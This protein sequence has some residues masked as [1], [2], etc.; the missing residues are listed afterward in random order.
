MSQNTLN[1]RKFIKNSALTAA[2]FYIVPRHVL[3]KGYVPPSDKLNIGA[4]GAF[5]KGWVNLSNSWNNGAENI[6]AMSD[7]DWDFAKDSAKKWP[8]AHRYTDW[9]EMLNKEKDALDAVIVS[10][11]DHNH[12]VVAMAAMQLGKHVYVEKPL[13][14]NIYEA[15]MLTEAAAKCRLVTQ[16]G[17]QGTSSNGVRQLQEWY[18]AGIMGT[19]NRVHVWSDRPVWPQ[20]IPT[21]TKKGKMPKNMNW[22]VWIGPAQYRN[23]NPAY[24]PFKWRGWWEFGTGALGDMGCHIIDPPFKVLGLGYPTE[25]GCSG[26]AV[27]R[28]DW[29]P[30]YLP[31]SCPPA[32]VV[33]LKFPAT[34]KNPVPC[35]MIWYDGG[36]QPP[37][38]EEM[39]SEALPT[40]GAIFEGSKG[41]V[42][43]ELFGEKARLLPES[44]MQG[45]D[46]LNIKASIPRVEG[47][48]DGH[49]TQWV[50]A[51]KAGYSNM[52]TS[53]S[54][55]Y[56]GPLTEAV[57]MGNLA[58][59]S[60]NLR[61]ERSGG[62]FDFPGRKRLYWDGANMKITNFDEANQF[63]R[64][65]YRA[66]WSLGV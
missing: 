23:F 19:V 7:V 1:R 53:S 49:Q 58:I 55:D 59:R 62:G 25:G 45:S 64:R 39:G 37:V 14:H 38:P 18:N 29:I 17:N 5:G 3:G 40:N 33:H 46:I 11:P 56:S 2:G 66:G 27:F 60:Y 13:T 30:E 63:V 4:V 28:Q 43:C 22:D 47:G 42:I 20:G 51:C 32:S 35:E 12:A 16:M 21:P 61:K 52:P 31:D 54:F 15:R 26:A 57:I 24:H 41:K 9:R 6:V 10:T 36:M 44:R 34:A 8:K 48:V 50:N 65:Q